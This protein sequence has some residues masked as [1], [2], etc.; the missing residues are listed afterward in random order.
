MLM[1]SKIEQKMQD[2][3]LTK[4][5]KLKSLGPYISVSG[6]NLVIFFQTIVSVISHS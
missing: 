5:H 3:K 6:F 4:E 1:S 2:K